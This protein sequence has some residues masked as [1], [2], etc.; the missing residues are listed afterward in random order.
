MSDTGAVEVQGQGF[1]I[2]VGISESYGGDP[3]YLYLALGEDC[4]LISSFNLYKDEMIVKKKT[5]RGGVVFDHS[6]YRFLKNWGVDRRG[7][8]YKIEAQ[9]TASELLKT[10][11]AIIRRL[12][13]DE[14]KTKYSFISVTQGGWPYVTNG[15]SGYLLHLQTNHG[16]AAMKLTQTPRRTSYDGKLTINGYG[17]II[18]PVEDVVNKFI[19]NLSEFSDPFAGRTEKGVTTLIMEK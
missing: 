18:V 2:K 15:H 11:L 9:F 8:L 5:G 6:P 3:E 7:R 17:R 13:M 4:A 16:Y 1:L 14:P 12:G 10:S 19:K